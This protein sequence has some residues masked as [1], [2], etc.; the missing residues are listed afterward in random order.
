MVKV[1]LVLL[2][3]AVTLGI[4]GLF[5]SSLFGRTGRATVATFI[6]VLVIMIGPLFLT[7]L[8]AAIQQGEPPRWILAPSPISALSAALA[9]SMGSNSGRELFFVLGGMFN[10]G[11]APLS[12]VGIPRP[13]Y[14]YSLPLYVMLSVILYM[15]TTR[16][17]QPAHRWQF[18]RKEL[19]VA[20][21]F[22]LF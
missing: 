19:L 2:V 20:S 10:M 22:C 18:R 15:L 17:I 16:L 5:M 7:V 21:P 4:L 3:V 14:H 13:L 1:L 6:V 9:S 8:V 11:I 12:Q